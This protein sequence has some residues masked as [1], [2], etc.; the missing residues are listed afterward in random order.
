MTD[1]QEN[2]MGTLDSLLYLEMDESACDP[3][4]YDDSIEELRNQL[5]EDPVEQLRGIEPTPDDT[6]D[7]EEEDAEE[8]DI[9][10]KGIEH[11]LSIAHNAEQHAKD[12]E[13]MLGYL[14]R[15]MEKSLLTPWEKMLLSLHVVDKDL[16][17][18][19]IDFSLEIKVKH[20]CKFKSDDFDSI[21][22]IPRN[23][24]HSQ[25]PDIDT[26]WD[27]FVEGL[28]RISNDVIIGPTLTKP[29][30]NLRAPL[31][32]LWNYPSWSSH[33][34]LWGQVVD[35]SNPCLRMQYA[36]LGP[37]SFIKT[38][39]RIP[40]REHW[41]PEGVKWEQ[42]YP[43]WA[44]VLEK[45][46]ELNV[47]LNTQSKIIIL[48]GKENAFMPRDKI[49]PMDESMEILRIE[50][51][52]HKG[53]PL[54]FKE[55]PWFEVIRNRTTKKIHHLLFVSYHTQA[56]FYDT[57]D[58]DSRVYHDLV[59]NAAC[60][61]AGIP[62]PR[63]MYFLRQGSFKK[64]ENPHRR[65][66]HL[67]RAIMLRCLEK[68]NGNILSKPAVENAFYQL[69]KK[70]PSLQLFPDKNG[71]FVATIIRYYIGKAWEKQSTNTWRQS[72]EAAS[73]F[74]TAIENLLE[75]RTMAKRIATNR[76]L[77]ASEA[78]R[79][80]AGGKNSLEGLNKGRK[81]PK[82]RNAWPAKV[83][84]FLRT[85]QVQDMLS[86]RSEQLTKCQRQ[87]QDRLKNLQSESN[88]RLKYYFK[89]HVIWYSTFYPTGLRFKGDGC[90]MTDDFPYNE[91]DHPAVKLQGAWKTS[92]RRG[93]EVLG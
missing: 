60:G 56:F 50:L 39:N 42:K 73:M 67:N 79:Q 29:T 30:G 28:T 65:L 44:S 27:V 24:W 59:W 68:Q 20:D 61:L 66:V 77:R 35:E 2:I 40:I 75:P 91:I 21:R 8:N 87:S 37:S 4:V 92:E 84:A 22:N 54:L 88:C 76:A 9:S 11:A 47:W 51:C 72:P 53:R 10:R 78:W 17:T 57:H 3:S 32:I 89:S 25:D 85:K 14:G 70:N 81:R 46:H 48:V 55:Q 31:T 71:S 1:S 69:L 63:P 7:L 83:E 82:K 49:V 52:K 62:V 58:W 12:V 33:R 13:E 74:D 38:Q 15:R 43:N 86:A 6:D 36:K 41:T 16:M 23:S 90:S 80:S 5:Q 64:T 93:L 34:R 19:L 26:R 18:Q 45:C